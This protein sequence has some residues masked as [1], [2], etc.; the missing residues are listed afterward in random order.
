MCIN[1][2]F[3]DDDEPLIV[4]LIRINP[5]A[6]GGEIPEAMQLVPPQTLERWANIWW[7]CNNGRPRYLK[8]SNLFTV[9]ILRK[10]AAKLVFAQ[11]GPLL[12]GTICAC[13]FSLIPEMPIMPI[14]DE[15][16]QIGP[17]SLLFDSTD[18]RYVP[19]MKTTWTRLADAT[20]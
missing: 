17:L 16:I 6:H 7:Q 13:C 15:A 10:K 8:L 2:S 18:N 12:P 19:R 1:A 14:V 5:Q 4:G 11:R 9:R 20:Y 3:H